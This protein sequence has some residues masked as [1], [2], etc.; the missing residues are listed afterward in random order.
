[1]EWRGVVFPGRLTSSLLNLYGHLLP[2]RF[3]LV[4]VPHPRGVQSRGNDV[5]EDDLLGR[6]G[7]IRFLPNGIAA[8][9]VRSLDERRVGRGEHRERFRT[10]KKSRCII[11]EADNFVRYTFV[12]DPFRKFKR[13]F[14]G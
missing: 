5:P 1:M 9:F 13:E 7:T 2:Q 6:V 11:F 8:V 3:L 10:C 4:V 12:G 14:V